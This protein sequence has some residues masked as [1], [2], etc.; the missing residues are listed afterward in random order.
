MPDGSTL[1]MLAL[2]AAGSV[3]SWKAL[4][5]IT[6]L[7]GSQLRSIERERINHAQTV[8]KL[9]EKRDLGPTRA[10]DLHA[11]ERI[12]ETAV[13]AQ[14]EREVQNGRLPRQTIDYETDNG[15]PCSP[16]EAMHQ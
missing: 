2:I 3:L 13:L 8:Q 14:L 11:R 4:S 12:N 7:T 15:Q 16:E 5:V 10:A 9:M 1:L 6:V